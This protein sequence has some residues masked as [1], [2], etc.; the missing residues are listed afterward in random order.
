M[1]SSTR[2]VCAIVSI[3]KNEPGVVLTIVLHD[4]GPPIGTQSVEPGHLV[5]GH[6]ID[7][8]LQGIGQVFLG[9]N[10]GCIGKRFLFEH[11]AARIPAHVH[12]A[13]HLVLYGLTVCSRHDVGA[14][15]SAGAV[16]YITERSRKR[17]SRRCL[18][19]YI[20]H[21]N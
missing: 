4:I 8:Y 9:L 20:K 19:F 5:P 15:G 18:P 10:R 17:Q 12:T 7:L 11:I 3:A 14:E 16:V 1:F 6:A 2:Q 21:R 13:K